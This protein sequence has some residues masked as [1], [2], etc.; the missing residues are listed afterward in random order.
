MR[1]ETFPELHGHHIRPRAACARAAYGGDTA[2]QI[3]RFMPMVKRLA[4]HA[5]GSGR[6]GIEIEDLI[7][8]GL[9]ALTE[10]IQRHQ[11]QGENAFKAYAKTRVHGAMFDLIR[12]EAPTTRTASRKQREINGEQARLA[13][14]LGRMPTE[15]ELASALGMGSGEF[16]AMR[17]SAQPLR[18]DPIDDCYADTNPAFADQ[19]PD[20]HAMLEDGE[21]RDRLVAAIMALPE[22]LQRI[23]QLY[24]V[25]ELNLTEIA[26][27]LEVSVPRVHQLKG[28]ALAAL[29]KSLGEGLTV[30]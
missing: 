15:G 18:F 26:A 7:Q 3:R 14:E 23:T 20:T 6:P 5:N 9:M 8:V 1:H 21:M 11:G 12:R 24:F 2:E 27:I 28:Q 29:R 13:N 4:W 22:R 16:A 19:S 25:E 10:C 17:A 30:F